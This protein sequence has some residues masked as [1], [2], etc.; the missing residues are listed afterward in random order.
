MRSGIEDY[1]ML[2]VLKA[3]DPA[4]AEQIAASAVS[5]F[6]EYVRDAASFRSIEQRLL[7]ALSRR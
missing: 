3:R 6:T 4:A 2:R 1:E 5:S 7:E